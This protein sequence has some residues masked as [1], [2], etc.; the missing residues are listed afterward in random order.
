MERYSETGEE[1]RGEGEYRWK[2][3]GRDGNNQTEGK[4]GEMMRE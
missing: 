3:K 2:G 1:G 4:K